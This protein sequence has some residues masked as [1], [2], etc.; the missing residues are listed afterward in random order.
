MASDTERAHRRRSRRPHL[1]P[2]TLHC[3]ECCST[4]TRPSR[5]K[6]V[7]ISVMK[8]FHFTRYKCMTC[9]NRF[10]GMA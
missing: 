4:E 3:P 10:Y 1:M 2:T 6:G 9:G 7:L 5:K 8:L